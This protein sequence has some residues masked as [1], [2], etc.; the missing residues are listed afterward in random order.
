VEIR[1]ELREAV[2]LARD[3]RFRATVDNEGRFH[4]WA[5]K[6]IDGGIEVL[7]GV[8]AGERKED[9]TFEEG[10]VNYLVDKR[11]RELAETMRRFARGEEEGADDKL[12]RP[13]AWS[14][15]E[16][17]RRD[18]LSEKKGEEG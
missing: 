3:N 5:V 18:S 13:I 10:T 6:T 4:I 16:A 8:R 17:K 14:S 2:F 12:S 7:T 15:N 11:L 9:G 1:A